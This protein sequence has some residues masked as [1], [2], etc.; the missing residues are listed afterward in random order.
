MFPTQLMFNRTLRQANRD[1]GVAYGQPIGIALAIGLVFTAM[2]GAIDELEGFPL[3]SYRDWVVPGTLFLSAVVGAGFC[4]SE[5]LRDAQTGYLDRVRASPSSP[6][7]LLLGRM[8][9]E[10]VRGLIAASVVLTVGLLSGAQNNSGLAGFVLAVVL[11]ASLAFAW[12]GVFFF[13]AVKTLNPAAVLG[14]QPLFF[15]VLLFS[16]WFAP[17]TFMPDWYE[18]IARA[19]PISAYLD[20]LRSVFAGDTDWGLL[21]IAAGF[22]VALA[23]A[24]TVLATRAY[25]NLANAR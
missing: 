1:A 3:P 11:T 2:F 15:P 19:N 16:S 8:A 7:G 13:A 10:F 6:S 23:A 17:R 18:A 14:L 21:A 9:F 4:A 20:G 22:I 5:L 25:R 12:N 24:S